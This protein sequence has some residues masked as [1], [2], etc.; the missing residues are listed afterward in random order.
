[1]RR[2]LDLPVWRSEPESSYKEAGNRSS[3]AYI[4]LGS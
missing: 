3:L 2:P 1:M 4:A